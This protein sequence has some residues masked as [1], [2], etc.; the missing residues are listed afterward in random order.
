[1]IKIIKN[2][3]F[4]VLIILVSSALYW[5]IYVD[6]SSK[7]DSLDYVL[8]LFGNDLL[9]KVQEPDDK[10]IV[11]D[12]F[13]EFLRHTRDKRINPKTIEEI[14]VDIINISNAETTLTHGDAEKLLAKAQFEMDRHSNRNAINPPPSEPK[15]RI[16]LQWKDLDKRLLSLHTL[17]KNLN[18]IGEPHEF[19]IGAKDIRLLVLPEIG[20]G[21]EINPKLMD[22][23]ERLKREE[24]VKNFQSIKQHEYIIQNDSIAKSM[25]DHLARISSVLDSLD[26]DS[27]HIILEGPDSLLK[28]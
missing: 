4:F 24:L 10:K 23:I 27:L 26:N 21:I 6:Q 11:Q 7:Q 22:E 20:K 3:G 19:I 18:S 12:R 17:N 1:M 28:E 13:E 9:A 2:I 16:T 8:N 15:N 5:I 14:A 25:H